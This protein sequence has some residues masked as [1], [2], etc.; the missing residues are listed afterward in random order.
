MTRR[1][2]R[3]GDGGEASTTWSYG[4][5]V[6]RRTRG[7]S[8]KAECGGNDDEAG[9]ALLSMSGKRMGGLGSGEFA[10]AVED[11]KQSVVRS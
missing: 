1:S 2:R 10:D 3:G 4:I 8:D 5:L 6:T 7:D 11:D 9:G